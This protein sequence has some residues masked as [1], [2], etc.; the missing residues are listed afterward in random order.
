MEELSRERQDMTA[1]RQCADQAQEAEQYVQRIREL[2]L[3]HNLFGLVT[4]AR[5][6]LSDA[7]GRVGTEQ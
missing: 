7:D 3:S 4:G 1:A 5:T 6:P 2:V